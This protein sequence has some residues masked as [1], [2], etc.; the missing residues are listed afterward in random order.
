MF[1]PEIRHIIGNIN[2]AHAIEQPTLTEI[3]LLLKKPKTNFV[4]GS[5][6]TLE[7]VV[8]GFL[9]FRFFLS[10]FYAEHTLTFGTAAPAQYMIINNKRKNTKLQISEQKPVQKIVFSPVTNLLTQKGFHVVKTE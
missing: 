6:G 9:N 4:L 5:V 3:F 8:R 2:V 1:E 10:F 7:A